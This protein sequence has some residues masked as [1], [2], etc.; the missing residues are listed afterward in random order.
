M[1]VWS[2]IQTIDFYLASADTLCRGLEENLE[3][4]NSKII[5]EIESQQKDLASVTAE[6]YLFD[7]EELVQEQINTLVGAFLSI[8]Y[9]QIAEKA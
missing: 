4:A 6:D 7:N 9:P 3:H 8:R 2:D 1:L 5:P